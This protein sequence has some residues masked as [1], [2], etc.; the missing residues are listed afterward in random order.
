MSTTT[1]AAQHTPGPWIYIESRGSIRTGYK[2]SESTCVAQTNW[3]LR[4]NRWAENEA[5]ARLISAAPDLADL[6]LRMYTHISHGAPTR[7][8]AEVVLKK[9]GLL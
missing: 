5:N 6:V 3:M 8:E 4:K 2:N 1:K 9:A 7:V